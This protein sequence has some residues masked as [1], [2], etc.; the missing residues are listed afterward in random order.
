M[1]F[2]LKGQ[3]AQ[4]WADDLFSHEYCAECGGDKEDHDIIN[5]CGNWFAKCKYNVTDNE[6]NKRGRF[7][8]EVDECEEECRKRDDDMLP[9]GVKENK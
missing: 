5:F 9:V 3:T 8:D 7:K 6:D 2:K 1:E 4:E